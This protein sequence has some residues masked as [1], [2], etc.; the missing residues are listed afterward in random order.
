MGRQRFDFICITD[1]PAW[2]KDIFFWTVGDLLWPG[3]WSKIALFNLTSTSVPTLYFDLDTCITGSLF[4]LVEV[5]GV[6]S[7]VTSFWM[8]E[9]F[10][11]Q[12][13]VP[14]ASRWAS[15]I[16]AWT[17]NWHWLTEEFDY[18]HD[19]KQYRGDQEY[20]QTA[21]QREGRIPHKIQ[22]YLKVYSYKHHCQRGTPADADVV[23]FHGHPR[24]H[25][26][27]GEWWP[28]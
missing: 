2:R 18:P 14:N 27:G 21:L 9:S 16:M 20:I 4:S 8:M 26:V 25:E 28:N 22:D 24:P 6:W 3:W 17:G 11:Y 15:G 7:D 1:L 19:S 5:L 12:R 13:G 23:C 10:R